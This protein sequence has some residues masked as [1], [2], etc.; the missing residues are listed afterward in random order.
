MSPSLIPKRS[1]NTSSV[2]WPSSGAGRTVVGDYRSGVI[3]ERVVG[4]SWPAADNQLA[5]LEL[6]Y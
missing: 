1:R 2:C 4:R 6:H 3:T 5:T